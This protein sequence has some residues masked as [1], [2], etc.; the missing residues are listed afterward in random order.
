MITSK[1]AIKSVLKRAL[2][3]EFPMKSQAYN[4]DAY[5]IP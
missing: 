3:R 1:E 5:R 2:S 4:S